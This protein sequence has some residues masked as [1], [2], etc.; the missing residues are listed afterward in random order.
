MRAW[1]LTH[2]IEAMSNGMLAPS[3]RYRQRARICTSR[4]Q[5]SRK[6]VG[7]CST[8]MQGLRPSGRHELSAL[9]E[10]D[11]AATETGAIAI[12][13]WEAVADPSVLGYRLYVGMSPHVYQWQLDVGLTTSHTMLNLQYNTTYYVAVTAYNVFGESAYSE[14]ARVFPH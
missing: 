12:L 2:S 14:E 11:T 3:G 1:T 4:R 7:S 13:R 6:L 10:N 5:S 9:I 8:R